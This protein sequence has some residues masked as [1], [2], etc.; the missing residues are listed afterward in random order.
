MSVD[1][2]K[3]QAVL[4]VLVAAF[5]KLKV[6]V[7]AAITAAANG[8]GDVANQAAIDSVT[9]TLENTSAAI[10]GLDAS[11]LPAAPAA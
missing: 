9:A 8:A 3:L 11:I 5:D 7:P 10:S 2:S 6:D 4:P 1:I